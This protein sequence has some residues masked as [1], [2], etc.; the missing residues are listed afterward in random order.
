MHHIIGLLEQK[1]QTPYQCFCCVD[2]DNFVVEC[3]RLHKSAPQLLVGRVS[4]EQIIAVFCLAGTLDQ[5][6]VL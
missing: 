1:A 3:G 5:S 6:L 2:F 4:T